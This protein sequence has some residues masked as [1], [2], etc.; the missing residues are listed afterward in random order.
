[1]KNTAATD[2]K[3]KATVSVESGEPG[4]LRRAILGFLNDYSLILIFI[5]LFAALSF[6]VDHFFSVENMLGLALSVSQIGM[7]ACT[8]MF[9]LA[10]RDFDLSVG[11][12]VAFSGVLCAM[13]LNAAGNA[14]LAGFSA[15]LCGALIG[16]VNGF[17][18]AYL[19]INALITTL[20][21]MEIVRGLA[22][23]ASN[24]QALASPTKD[25]SSLPVPH[26]LESRCQY[27]SL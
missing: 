7:V 5:L 27:G 1:M 21:T 14:W 17:I 4:D 20:A 2:E 25:S 15:V 3:K 10:S 19:R 12:T 6:L 16:F 22:F 24:G 13:V 9:C 8:M 23:I 26:F 11:S 18:I